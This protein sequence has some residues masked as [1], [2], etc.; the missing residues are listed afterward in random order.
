MHY[1]TEAVSWLEPLERF[2]TQMGLKEV[3]PQPK[4][5]VTKSSVPLET[6]VV[7]LD[8]SSP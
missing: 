3:I 8:Y 5:S 6:K 1:R 2:T 7:V 4:L